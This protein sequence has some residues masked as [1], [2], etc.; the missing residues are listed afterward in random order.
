MDE[1]KVETLL[2]QLKAT[3]ERL[4]GRVGFVPFPMSVAFFPGKP[5]QVKNEPFVPEDLR[6]TWVKGHYLSQVNRGCDALGYIFEC[7]PNED[8]KGSND[9]GSDVGRGLMIILSAADFEVYLS[10]HIVK[11]GDTETVSWSYRDDI[12]EFNDQSKPI[13]RDLFVARN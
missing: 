13:F 12:Y 7:E 11:E 4:Y 2:A 9:P 3:A 10:G 1:A 6:Q 5:Y 8:A